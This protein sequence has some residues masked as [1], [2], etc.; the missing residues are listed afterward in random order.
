MAVQL[1][2][3]VRAHRA[4][5]LCSTVQGTT[6]RYT[7]AVLADATWVGVLRSAGKLKQAETSKQQLNKHDHDHSSLTRSRE[8][9]V[10][11]AH[12]H[13]TQV[14]PQHHAMGES[15]AALP[16]PSTAAAAWP[17]GCLLLIVLRSPNRVPAAAPALSLWSPV[18][19]LL[20]S[21]L[22]LAGHACTAPVR[23][24][25]PPPR[26]CSLSRHSITQGAQPCA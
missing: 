2:S 17:F 10:R 25:S 19:P 26:R 18:P 15:T 5:T 1:D 16:P 22:P 6:A 20:R 3:D 12:T 21:V 7:A 11:P 14:A 9:A 4:S 23:T 13:S 24:S 8:A